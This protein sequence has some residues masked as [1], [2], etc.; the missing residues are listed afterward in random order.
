VLAAFMVGAGATHFVA[1]GAY[2]RIVPRTI[3][4]ARILVAASGVAEIVSGLLVALPRTRRIGAWATTVLLV[5]VF[6]ANVQM[7]LDGGI[8]GSGFPTNSAVLSWIRLPLQ[9]PLVVWAWRQGRP[10]TEQR[11]AAPA[12]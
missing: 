11:R 4:H 10:G 7:A 12:G 9:V 3:G 2:A 5:A 1:P 8:P 6:P